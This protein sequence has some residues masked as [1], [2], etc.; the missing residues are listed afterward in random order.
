MQGALVQAN[1]GR[2]PAIVATS[3]IFALM[4]GGIAQ[5]HAIPA[6]FT[7]SLALGW[8]YERTGRL[9]A[10]IVMHALFNAAN[11]GLALLTR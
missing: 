11:L 7:L 8:V 3:A 10:P 6:L 2:W 1:L 9:T 4:H 5:P